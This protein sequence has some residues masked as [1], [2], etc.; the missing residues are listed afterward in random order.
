[1]WFFVH[2]PAMNGPNTRGLLGKGLSAPV[3]TVVFC[4]FMPGT[5]ICSHKNSIMYQKNNVREGNIRNSG[6]LGGE[7]SLTGAWTGA[8]AG[9]EKTNA[10]PRAIDR[11]GAGN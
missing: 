7:S 10:P 11:G 5:C 4:P 2:V 9:V 6:A 8:G 1:M 3:T